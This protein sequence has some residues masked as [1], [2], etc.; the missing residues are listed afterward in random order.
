MV[1]VDWQ[2]F[3]ELLKLSKDKDDKNVKLILKKCK[4]T[5]LL[6]LPDDVLNKI[7]N[8]VKKD[9]KKRIEDEIYNNTKKVL[10]ELFENINEYCEEVCVIYEREITDNFIKNTFLQKV[11]FE[12][13]HKY[14]KFE[15]LP[16]TI[17]NKIIENIPCHIGMYK[18]FE[19]DWCQGSI[20]R[21]QLDYYLKN[22]QENRIEV[23]LKDIYKNLLL[24]YDA[25]EKEEKEER[26]KREQREKMRKAIEERKRLRKEGFY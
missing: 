16:Y 2:E 9:N 19:K 24:H 5:E 17:I 25:T 15:N 1:R 11:N 23:I 21:K 7:G 3:Y 13:I 4:H 22:H 18:F 26:E 12:N 8:M 20:T 6:D 14:F 10:N